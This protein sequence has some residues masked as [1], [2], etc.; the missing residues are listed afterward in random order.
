MRALGEDG[1]K[2]IAFSLFSIFVVSAASIAQTQTSRVQLSASNTD[3]PLS[4]GGL[5]FPIIG[6]AEVNDGSAISGNFSGEWSGLN[7]SYENATMSFS[8][9]AAAQ[10]YYGGMHTYATGSLTGSFYNS[11]NTP[12][13]NSQTGE[14]NDWGVPDVVNLYAQAGWSDKLMVGSTAHNYYSTWIFDVSGINAGEESFAYLTVQVGNNAAVPFYFGLG[15]TNNTLRV[16]Q[17][18]VGGTQEDITFNLYSFFQ[19]STQYFADG[20]YV[21]G[22]SNFGHTV[23]LQ[24]IEFR[25]APGGDIINGLTLESASGYQYSTVPEPATMAGLTLGVLALLRKRRKS[26]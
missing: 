19:P 3:Y 25:D 17:Y 1:M 2:R 22:S 12:Y 13:M 9:Y 10:G 20:A 6:E 23:T 5:S 16:S 11:E 8:G 15:S 18:I 24:G 21:E 26:A 14:F 7:R 4:G